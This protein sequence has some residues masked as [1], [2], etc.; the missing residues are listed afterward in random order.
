MAIVSNS[1]K[2]E[3]S[4]TRRIVFGAR[5]TGREEKHTECHQIAA[6]HFVGIFSKPKDIVPVK[7]TI[8]V[9]RKHIE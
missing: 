7:G 8:V 2:S 9:S 1:R 4:S 5:V 3:L 6:L